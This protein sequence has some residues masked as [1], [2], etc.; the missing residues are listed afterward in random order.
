MRLDL[1][2]ITLNGMPFL[3]QHLREFNRMSCMWHWW[4]VEGAAASK[5]CT[6]WCKPQGPEL[7]S[8]GTTQYLDALAASHP[9]VT[10]FRQ[11][12]WDGK[13][14]MVNRPLQEIRKPGVVVQVDSDELHRADQLD[15]ISA[16]FAADLSIG[17]MAFECN[18]FIGPNIICTDRSADWVRA[19]RHEPGQMFVSHEP[20]VMAK[21]KGRMMPRAE[22][23]ANGLVFDHMSYVTEASVQYKEARY[24]YAGATAQWRKFQQNKAW[25]VK[26]LRDH[27][28][29]A[30]ENAT[31]DLFFK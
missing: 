16:L 14:E 28:S 19:W 29:F 31:A 10:V 4:I 2:T 8:D 6:S 20:P 27:L 12:L 5:H 7:S 26:R 11:P 9:R 13:L 21:Q 30:G 22:T 1:I 15:R 3:A 25:P 18:Y 17:S 24:G 23:V